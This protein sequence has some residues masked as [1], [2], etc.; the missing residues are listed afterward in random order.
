MPTS[1]RTEDGDCRV[2]VQALCRGELETSVSAV[3]AYNSRNGNAHL[4]VR[5]GRVLVYVEDR[6]ALIAFTSAWR[7]AGRLGEALFPPV[8]DAFDL[9]EARAR[10]DFERGRRARP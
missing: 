1:S 7:R 9:A 8:P 2:V 6:E 4:A 3:P 5:V 10:R